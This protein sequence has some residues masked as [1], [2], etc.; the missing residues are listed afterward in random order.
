MLSLCMI[1]KNE[2]AFLQ[3]CLSAVQPYVDEIIIV[4]TGSTDNT[5]TIAAQFTSKIHDFPWVDSF[6]A[7]R[8]FSIRKA[9]RD[10]ILVLDADEQINGE[11]FKKISNIVQTAKAEGHMLIQRNYTNNT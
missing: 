8:N 11:D 4:D 3:Q 7:A 10:W 2:Q 6:A 9:Q 5:K 1:V